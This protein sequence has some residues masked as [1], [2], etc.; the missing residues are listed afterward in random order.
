MAQEELSIAHE[1]QEIVAHSYR[2]MQLA[3]ATARVLGLAPHEVYRVGVAALLHDLGKLAIPISILSKPCPLNPEEWTIMH[4]HP[5]IGHQMLLMA[6]GDPANLGSIVVAH[7]E[8]WD[9][10]G[11]PLGLTKDMIPLEARILSVADAYDAMTSP[12]IYRQPFSSEEAR[13]ELE[14]CSGH[15]FDPMVVAAFLQVLDEQELSGRVHV[16]QDRK[17]NNGER[18]R[19]LSITR[20]LVTLVEIAILASARTDYL[21]GSR[22]EFRRRR[23]LDEVSTQQGTDSHA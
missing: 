6:N 20:Y 9:G 4:R 12:R 10:G 16:S 1:H 22:I 21:L 18:L 15:Q 7:H 23:S 11:Y 19:N 14:R 5:E 2:L 8:R 17:N 13:E 3:R